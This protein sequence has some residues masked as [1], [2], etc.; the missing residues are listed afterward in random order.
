MAEVAEVVAA[1]EVVVA[2]AAVMAVGMVV[3][4]VQPEQAQQVLVAAAAVTVAGVALDRGL[5]P[6]PLAQAAAADTVAVVGMA[7]VWVREAA[8]GQARALASAVRATATPRALV[9]V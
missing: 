2:E 9:M 7:P 8:M 5:G 4:R 6:E 3:V 1:P